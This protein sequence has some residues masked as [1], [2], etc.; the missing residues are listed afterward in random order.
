V[1]VEAGV[2]GV[3]LL[4]VVFWCCC[5]AVRHMLASLFS[6]LLLAG[7]CFCDDS[8]FVFC[9]VGSFGCLLL[10]YLGFLVYQCLLYFLLL[11]REF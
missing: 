3:L 1:E 11:F 7:S 4:A 9:Y 8:N 5:I 10:C 2:C 6:V